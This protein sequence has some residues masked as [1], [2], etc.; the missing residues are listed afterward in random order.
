M[1]CPKCEVRLNEVFLQEVPIEQCPQCDGLWLDSGEFDLIAQREKA[2]E[3]WLSKSLK[4]VLESFQKRK[5]S[6]STKNSGGVSDA[7]NDATPNT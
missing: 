7:N 3:G 2:D 1:N 4:N 6:D 5:T